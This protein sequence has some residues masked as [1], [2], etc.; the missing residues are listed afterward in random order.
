VFDGGRGAE[1]RR[2]REFVRFDYMASHEREQLEVAQWIL[3][4]NLHWIAAAEV[5]VAV[6]VAI[7]TGMLGALATLIT[8][9]PTEL[10][11]VWWV[12][13]VG[14]AFITLVLGVFCAAMTIIPRTTGPDTLLFFGRIAQHASADYV[15]LFKKRSGAAMLEDCLL[16]VH[17][18]S[19]IARDK[20]QWV[21]ASMLW[22]FLAVTFWVPALTA[23]VRA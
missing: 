12:F 10:R 7:D 5:K 23:L 6:V 22:S 17:R 3:E 21:R 16:Q 18:N 4:R 15:E 2:L 13:A 1:S 9:S 11:P 20:Y 14:G 19:E 8:Q